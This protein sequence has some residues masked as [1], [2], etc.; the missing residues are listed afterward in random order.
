[1]RARP[2]VKNYSTDNITETRI[3]ALVDKLEIGNRS[4]CIRLAIKQMHEREV[5]GPG[6]PA[7]G[8]TCG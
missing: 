4:L 6:A 2:E 8:E 7:N 3:G 5:A 1:M